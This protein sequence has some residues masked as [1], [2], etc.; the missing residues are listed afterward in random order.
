MAYAGLADC[1]TLRSDYGFLAPKEGYALAKGSITLALKY[2]ESLAEAHTSLASIK[3]VTDWDWQGRRMSIAR[4]IELNPKYATAHHW[5]AAQL[6]LQG[7]L[8]QALQE[9]RTAQQLDPLSLGINKD[10]AVILLYAR[11]YEKALEQCRKTL[12]IEPHIGAMSTYIAQIY[13]LQ[14]KYPEATAELEKA[15]AADPE[16]SEITYALAQAYALIGKKDE[17]LK[18]SDELNQPAKQNVFLPKEAAYLV[19]AAR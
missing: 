8:D 9:I 17:A 18:I 6:L 7:R 19:C 2:D 11:D 16:D 1:Y 14:Q 13:E 5:Y 12:E 4:A 3:A 10:F 15:H